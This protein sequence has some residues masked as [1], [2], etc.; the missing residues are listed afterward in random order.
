[1]TGITQ[2]EFAR[3]QGWS[4]SY[5]TKLK[6]Q[7]RLVFLDDGKTVDPDAS[8]T[9]INATADPNRDDVRKRWAARREQDPAPADVPPSA[10][11]A[12]PEGDDST[13]LGYQNSRAL[14]EHYLALQAQA[15]YRQTIG[16]LVEAAGVRRAGAE[17]GT[18]LRAALEN[19]PDQLA[20]EL[21]VESDPE[22][23]HALLVEQVEALL[24]RFTA[25]IG[26]LAGQGAA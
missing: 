19:L 16:Q 23:V 26:A 25:E 1:M 3:Q 14:K 9:R 4:K 10:A 6:R 12:A 20:Q 2:A 24:H 5:V 17:L 7:G 15:E 22:R 18:A 8:I 13:H 21:A 11:P